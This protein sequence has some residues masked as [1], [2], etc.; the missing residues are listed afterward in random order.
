MKPASNMSRADQTRLFKWYKDNK[1]KLPW[2]SNKKTPYT[3]W[4]S[5]VMLQQTTTKAVVHYY[6]TFLKRFK[7]LKSLALA[8]LEEVL[9]VW[10]GLGYYSRAKNLHKAAQIIHKTKNFPKSYKELLKLPGFGPYTA[11]AVSSLAFG[12]KVGVLDANVIRVLCRYL[13]LK[14]QWWNTNEKNKLQMEVNKWVKHYSP[15]IMNQALMELGALV[16]TAQNPTCLICPLN[17]NCKALKKNQV[18][19]LPLKRTQKSKEIWFW[20]PIIAIKNPC[21]SQLSQTKSNYQST[22]FLSKDNQIAFI[23][24]KTLP[25]FKGEYLFPGQVEQRQSVPKNYD[26]IHYITHHS[27]Y[28]QVFLFSDNFHKKSTIQNN[29]KTSSWSWVK[30]KDIK[31]TNP[32][33]LIQKVLNIAQKKLFHPGKMFEFPSPSLQG[34]ALSRK[35]KR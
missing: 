9:E 15:P 35:N 2:R 14:C 1:R 32:S 24:N 22:Y 33:S 34:Q 12:E 25:V 10:S 5:E 27:I 7:T 11:R 20:Q 8:P 26:F 28:V 21:S 4:I 30:T 13:N 18:H 19:K 23:K 16:C 6:Q 3:I 31:K 17:K 29:R